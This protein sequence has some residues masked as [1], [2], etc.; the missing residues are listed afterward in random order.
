MFSLPCSTRQLSGRTAAACTVFIITLG[1]YVLILASEQNEVNT[2]ND[3][4]CAR[5]IFVRRL[6][7][8]SPECA[9]TFFGGAAMCSTPRGFYVL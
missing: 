9:V 5:R 4:K 6:S 2:G 8:V 7:T 1:L 3:K